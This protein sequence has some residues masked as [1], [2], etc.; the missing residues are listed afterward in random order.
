MNN[1]LALNNQGSCLLRVRLGLMA[2][3]R[4][5]KQR[6]NGDHFTSAYA[7][8]GLLRHLVKPFYL[9]KQSDLLS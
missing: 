1:G 7:H 9:Q 4:L 3:C 5:R 8:A 2:H 6:A